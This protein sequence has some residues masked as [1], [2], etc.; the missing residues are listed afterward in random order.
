MLQ[1]APEDRVNIMLIGAT[2]VGKSSAINSILGENEAK[3]GTGADPETSFIVRYSNDSIILWDTPGLGD[4]VTEDDAY[5]RQIKEKLEEKHGSHYLIDGVFLLI[6]ASSRDIGTVEKIISRVLHPIFGKNS[7]KRVMVVLNKVDEALS[8]R[9]WN[10]NSC[11]PENA[12][13]QRLEA[14]KESVQERLR[15]DTDIAFY[16]E[17]ISS[18]FTD[19][20]T[21]RQEAGYNIYNLLFKYLYLLPK[22]HRAVEKE[23]SELGR[24][25]RIETRKISKDEYSNIDDEYEYP[26]SFAYGGDYGT[27]GDKMKDLAPDIIDVPMPLKAWIY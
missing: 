24:G 8:G 5:I 7:A 27:M 4:G 16:T 6:D 1:R 20:R 9:Y 10:G 14:T 18:G 23:D 13:K 21:N 19:P 25:E 12:L 3:V 22:S 15:R 2:G 11:M 26:D 17:Y